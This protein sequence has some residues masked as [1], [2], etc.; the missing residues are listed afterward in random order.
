MVLVW[1]A[2]ECECTCRCSHRTQLH[3]TTVCECCM[4]WR[5]ICGPLGPFI[6]PQFM[7]HSSSL[8]PLLIYVSVMGSQMTLHWSR[9]MATQQG[10]QA[11]GR[12]GLLSR[13]WLVTVTLFDIPG[14]HFPYRAIQLSL[15]MDV[16]RPVCA[17]QSDNVNSTRCF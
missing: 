7:H 16:I 4:V 12:S 1:Q 11:M 15:A 14:T 2:A 10:L 17:K 8:T 3:R 13:G 9:L 5:F 6:T